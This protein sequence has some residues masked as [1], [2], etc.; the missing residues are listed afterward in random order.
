VFILPMLE[1]TNLYNA[2]SQNSARFSSANGPFDP[3]NVYGSAT[4]QQVSCVSLPALICPSW[5][6]DGYTNSNTTVDVGSSVG[7]PTTPEVYGASEYAAVVVPV[8]TPTDYSGKVGITNYKAMV[9]TH[10]NKSMH[11]VENGGFVYSGNQGLTEGAISDGSSKTIFCVETK[12]SSY[13]AWID[14]AVC[15]LVA[16]DPNATTAP[17][18]GGAD[19]APWDPKNVAI[20][21]NVGYNPSLAGV[22]PIPPNNHD[23]LPKAK[24]P[25]AASGGSMKFANSWWWGPS[26]DHGGGI[27]SHVYGDGH[28]LGVTDQCDGVTYL[29][30]TTRNGSEPIDD[31]KIN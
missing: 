27:V 15:W 5:A 13:A 17:G 24:A 8:K 28:T 22:T 7:A 10:I 9:G 29:G 6:G 18:V 4:N 25:A 1:E 11:L 16:N 14:G 19:V 20:A 30:L 23:Y 21:I 31:T 26:S 2:I 3:A 12:E